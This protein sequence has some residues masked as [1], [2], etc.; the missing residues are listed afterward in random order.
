MS[1]PYAYYEESLPL[2]QAEIGFTESADSGEGTLHE[3]RVPIVLPLKRGMFGGRVMLEAT[4][5][6][7][8][9]SGGSLTEPIVVL[10]EDAAERMRLKTRKLVVRTEDGRKHSFGY[11]R[12]KHR[13]LTLARLETWRRQRWHDAAGIA[14]ESVSELLKKNVINPMLYNVIVLTALQSL[15]VMYIIIVAFRAIQDRG[16][17]MVLMMLLVVLMYA[18][19]PMVTFALAVALWMR[20]IWAVYMTLILSF[21]PLGL[22]IFMFIFS[23]SLNDAQSSYIMLFP[24]LL[25]VAIIGS[26]I[27]VILRYNSQNAALE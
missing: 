26:S 20:Q 1:N 19:P 21:V 8:E 12:D 24:T 6:Q 13:E 22:S 17:E 5:D 7:C 27:R 23:L 16:S 14:Y 3:P 15:V 4:R 9:I 10:R 25:A 2:K 18:I 11:G